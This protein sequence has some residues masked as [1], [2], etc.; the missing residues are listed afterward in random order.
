M[1][2]NTYFTN[3]QLET[4]LNGWVSEYPKL[5]SLEEI[6]R[7]HENRPLRMLT[8]TNQATGPAENKPAVWI[9]ANIH[10]T[11][12][13]GT[14]TALYIAQTLLA[15]YGTTSAVTRLLDTSVFYIVPRINPDG[16]ALALAEHPKYIRSGSRPY[17]FAGEAATGCTSKIWTAMGGFCRCACPTPA[18]TG[19]SARW[20]RA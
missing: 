16:A 15:G 4:I 5:A 20:T 10:A 11:E 3:E 12:L 17:P 18:A 13:T 7:S 2:F 19:R 14:T 1:D 9:D 6:G 8:L